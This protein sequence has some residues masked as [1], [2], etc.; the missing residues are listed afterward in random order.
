M[1][2]LSRVRFPSSEDT[3]NLYI[4]GD[5]PL[6]L[7]RD[8]R[9]CY[10]SL[11][12]GQTLSLNTYFNSMYE[13]FYERYTTISTVHYVLTLEG[14]FTISIWR[15]SAENSDRQLLGRQELH[16]CS[17]V[18]PTNI[19]IP[20]FAQ[21]KH[22]GRIYFELI[23]LSNEGRFWESAI[24]TD[25]PPQENVSLGIISCTYKKENYIKNTVNTLLQDRFLQ[26]KLFKVFVVD[27]GKTLD[28]KTFDDA[29]TRLIPNRNVGGSGGFTRGLV[30]ALQ[31]ETYSHF[32]FMD[33]DVELDSEV[34]YRLF[35]LYEYAKSEFAIAGG[36]LDLHKKSLLFEAGA[37][38]AKSQFR[39]GFN[40]FE[41]SP[42]K[43]DLDLT[44]SD[45]LNALMVEEPV[46]Y[47]AFWFFAFP[48]QFIER[49]GLPMPFFIKGDDI[50]FGL[51]ISR[52]LKEK[53]V[54]FPAIAVWHEP[55]Y[56]KFPVWDSYYY[57]RNSLITHAV[58]GSLGYLTAIKDITV[59]LVYLLLFFDYNSTRMLIKAFE[60]YLQG[61]EF[62]KQQDPEA[63]HTYI[64]KLSRAYQ[65]Q[66]VDSTFSPPPKVEIAEAGVLQKIA[67]LLTLNGH[68]LP[69]FLLSKEDAFVW[70]GPGFPGQRSRAFA[71]KRVLIFK[72]KIQCLYSY[73]MD[74]KTG[75]KLLSTWL[76]LVIQSFSKWAKISAAWKAASQEFASEVFWRKY[77]QMNPK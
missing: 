62:I 17:A 23:C 54:A 20:H 9:G 63:L 29:R 72:E 39:E 10:A 7:N 5:Q 30:E 59:R 15:E 45:S 53:I 21:G 33:D 22:L 38:Y 57:F 6:T 56:A 60:D 47:G 50:E 8:E 46:D 37:N 55:F 41:L 70:Y 75:L 28:D 77:L 52:Q 49:M 65:N 12:K 11:Q 51:R 25:Q 14:T 58:Y 3:L 68:L 18:A 35:S 42:L 27:N 66:H 36:M 67:S 16:D 34:V 64:V 13:T 74:Q 19:E 1:T 73:D 44:K 71:K 26:N 31:E 48:A 61:P 32:L 4:Q 24:A 76:S 2:I 40:A 43:T 69:S